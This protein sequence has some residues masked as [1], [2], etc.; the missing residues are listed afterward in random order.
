MKIHQV[1]LG[2]EG[3]KVSSLIF[4]TEHIIHM[5]PA[6]GGALLSAAYQEFG[7]NHWDTALAYKSHPQVA[8][9][10]DQAGRENIIVTSKTS[11]KTAEEAQ[12]DLNR[13]FEELKT[14]YLDICFLHYVKTGEYSEHEDA[15]KYLVQVKNSGL[16]R[17][18]GLSSHSPSVIKETLHTP[19]IEI[20]CGTLNRDGS[21]IDDGDL[22]AMLEALQACHQVGK[23]VYVIKILGRGDLAHDVPGALKYVTQFDFIDAFN[24]GMRNLTEVRENVDLLDQFLKARSSS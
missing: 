6:Q 1:Q 12:A 22:N 13:I 11:A 7:I 4:G 14:S 24:I 3:P 20:V 23:G 19:E 5:P 2:T 17:H 21:R 15:L 18:I 16:I 9:G 8:A 10:L